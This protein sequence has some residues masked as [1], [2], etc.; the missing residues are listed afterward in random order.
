MAGAFHFR[1]IVSAEMQTDVMTTWAQ[2]VPSTG[3]RFGRSHS[4]GNLRP[5]SG[6]KSSPATF[7][8]RTRAKTLQLTAKTAADAFAWVCALTA[9][10]K[11]GSSSHIDVTSDQHLAARKQM[12]E[13]ERY[14]N[15]PPKEDEL[16]PPS[17]ASTASTEPGSSEPRSGISTCGV[18]DSGSDLSAAPM[19]EPRNAL[20]HGDS[21]DKEGANELSVADVTFCQSSTP[22]RA[23][24]APARSFRAEEFG[25][26]EEDGDTSNERTLEGS[27]LEMRVGTVVAKPCWQPSPKKQETCSTSSSATVLGQFL[28]APEARKAC[29]DNDA[30]STRKTIDT[31]QRVE[32]TAVN[33]LSVVNNAAAACVAPTHEAQSPECAV[34][35]PSSFA[36]TINASSVSIFTKKS[37]ATSEIAPQVRRKRV[38]LTASRIAADLSLLQPSAGSSV[39]RSASQGRIVVGGKTNFYGNDCIRI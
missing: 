21:S 39:K 10:R 30:H 6:Q 3:S 7:I 32:T 16:L 36:H 9:A 31:D 26:E 38:D 17:P 11:I 15:A 24:V 37:D 33:D 2:Q 19:S 25:F 27:I 28:G 4:S 29:V 20:G 22:E 18:S 1:E 14:S 34:R 5:S 35:E 8:V 13:R 23:D 12:D